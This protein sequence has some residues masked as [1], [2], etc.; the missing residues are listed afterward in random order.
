MHELGE[1]SL[2][3]ENNLQIVAKEMRV[4]N[5]STEYSFLEYILG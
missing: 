5:V 2:V 3:S 1:I 4:F